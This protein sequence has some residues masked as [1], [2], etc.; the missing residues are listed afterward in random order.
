MDCATN[1]LE[2]MQVFNLTDFN[3]RTRVFWL[4]IILCG[5]ACILFSAVRTGS[6]APIQLWQFSTL[7]LV[8]LLCARLTLTLP[9]NKA[10]ISPAD[11][12]VFLIGLLQGAEAAAISSMLASLITAHR[13][14]RNIRE[15]L[16]VSFAQALS[17]FFSFTLFYAYVG[18]Y[19]ATPILRLTEEQISLLK[20]EW[21]FPGAML[22]ALL[23]FVSNYSLQAVFEGWQK[24]ENPAERWLHSY[25]WAAPHV[26]VCA[27]SAFI[28]LFFSVSRGPLFLMVIAP[29]LAA[30][31]ATWRFYFERAAN[32][33]VHAENLQRLYLDTIETFATAVNAKDQTSRE[34]TM[35]VQIYAIN[36]GQ[37]LGLGEAEIEALRVGAVLHDIGNLAVPDYIL[38]KRERLSEAEFDKMK[39]H[40]IVGAQIVEQMKFSFPVA[41]IIRHHHERWDGQGYPDG[42]T[43]EE[44]PLT[45]RILSVADCFDSLRTD[46]PWHPAMMRE[47]AIQMILQRRGN[48]FDPDV[49][50]T[51]LANLPTF[52]A[53][54]TRKISAGEISTLQE[55]EAASSL[56]RFSPPQAT[57]RSS[58]RNE[59]MSLRHSDEPI[60][61]QHI[62]SAHHEVFTLYEIARCFSR[63]LNFEDISAVFNKM[64][65]QMIP[66]ET[67]AV[68]LLDHS[69]NAA[70]VE[71]AI[72]KNEA[73]F[74]GLELSPGEGITGWVLAN[75]Q[76]FCNGDP[77]LDLRYL[78]ISD[79]TYRSVI[80]VPMFRDGQLTGVLSLYTS[81]ANGYTSDHQRLLE[82]IAEIT[83]DAL[84]N[85]LYVARAEDTSLIDPLTRLGNGRALRLQFSRE[86]NRALRE[87]THLSLM[88]MN[89]DDFRRINENWGR[90]TGDEFLK[91]ISQIIAQELRS[92]D[93]L[94]RYSGDE[95]VALLPGIQQDALSE[96]RER[97]LKAAESF[98]LTAPDGEEAITTISL[99]TARFPDEA[100][101]L[102]K[103]LRLADRRMYK[104][105]F[106][107]RS[108][109]LLPGEDNGVQV[110]KM[111]LS[112]KQ[113]P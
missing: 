49:V 103:L 10:A 74:I 3:I 90:Q 102:E 85:A 29:L 22:L 81:Q 87:A 28:A 80:S 111:P 14:N 100:A 54:I 30:G 17:T 108:N 64:V 91:A 2:P 50:D 26:F 13:T 65:R 46:R 33:G 9:E 42:L 67:C 84:H 63:T 98:I 77:A 11:G 78:K 12:F 16:F 21:L 18:Q 31:F 7:T 8:A 1:Y 15:G 94:V 32:S 96:L 44:I 79:S 110:L 43:G 20:I 99:G 93:F 71:L 36:L 27:F 53:E 92:Y 73:G 76:S 40:T 52:E 66:F 57:T 37:A 95:F 70:T 106:M 5:S 24:G 72:G 83:A 41:P 88:I 51:F 6:Q 48:H 55:T 86:S 109:S 61:F 35:R 105:K 97:I 69:K 68:Y 82:M 19:L 47:Q 75:R 104:H 45:A 59:L 58:N 107:R 34:H 56:P 38:N 4:L 39:I 60:Y 23:Y 112:N 89:L 101:D 25:L 62:S 113:S